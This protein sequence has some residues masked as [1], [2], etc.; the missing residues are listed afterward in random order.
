VPPESGRDVLL[1]Q[2]H[3]F[4]RL[5]TVLKII[6][7][8]HQASAQRDEV[9]E[10]M[11]HWQAASR[12]MPTHLAGDK[13]AVSKV[14][15]FLRIKPNIVEAFEPSAPE[16]QVAGMA[17]ERPTHVEESL[18]PVKLDVGIKTDADVLEIAAIH[19]CVLLDHTAH[20][21]RS[22]QP[23]V[24][25]QSRPNGKPKTCESREAN[26]DPFTQGPVLP[27][28]WHKRDTNTSDSFDVL[29]RHRSRSIPQAQESA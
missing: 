8:D 16:I 17:V 20:K 15:E 24:A 18:G 4:K 27:R 7:P 14:E 29:L 9:K 28:V 10:R 6:Q 25:R 1:R 23:R 11:A 12:S 3:G 2:P 26:Q 22:A 19:R 5:R 13:K 21:D